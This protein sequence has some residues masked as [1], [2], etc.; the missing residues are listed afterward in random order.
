MTF[1]IIW[2]AKYLNIERLAKSVH[3]TFCAVQPVKTTVQHKLLNLNSYNS[4]DLH[5]KEDVR[6]SRAINFWRSAGHQSWGS[7][8]LNDPVPGDAQSNMGLSA[9]AASDQVSL[10][11]P[12]REFRQ[13][14]LA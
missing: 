14:M 13:E 12:V 11:K 3:R 5:A 9:R 10:G 2:H 8:K 7:F 1:V 6:F 4:Y